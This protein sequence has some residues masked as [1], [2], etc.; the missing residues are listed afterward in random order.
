MIFKVLT[1]AIVLVKSFVLVSG[2][3]IGIFVCLCGWGMFTVN[4]MILFGEW[5]SLEVL[6]VFLFVTSRCSVVFIHVVLVWVSFYVNFKCLHGHCVCFFFGVPSTKSNWLNCTNCIL[7]T[8][9]LAY[10]TETCSVIYKKKKKS[11]GMHVK[12]HIRLWS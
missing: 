2:W 11:W 3:D 1:K 7:F 9:S 5:F 10:D 12:Q 4:N 6:K 8:R